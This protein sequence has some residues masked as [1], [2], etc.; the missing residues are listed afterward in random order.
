VLYDYAVASDVIALRLLPETRQAL[1]KDAE[2][3]NLGISEYLRK[4]AEARA[5][6]IEYAHVREEGRRYMQRLR[7][8]PEAMAEEDA[9][10]RLGEETLAELGPWEG[11]LPGDDSESAPR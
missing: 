3:M 4:L 11:P 8:S 6:E 9:W 10:L 1:T 7:E 2:R 5:L